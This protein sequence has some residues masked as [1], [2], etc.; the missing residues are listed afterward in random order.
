MQDIASFG[1]LLS[2]F[3]PFF[4]AP[5]DGPAAGPAPATAELPD[6]AGIPASPATIA[7]DTAGE[8]FDTAP[9]PPGKLAGVYEAPLAA[10]A[11]RQSMAF[12]FQLE[13]SVRQ[14]RSV[15]TSRDTGY[16]GSSFVEAAREQTS[17]SYQS[18][19]ALYRNGAGGT[20]REVRSFQAQMFR[21][22]TRQLSATLDPEPGGRLDRTAGRVS[23]TFEL[24]IKFEASFLSQFVRQAEDIS[25][26][27]AGVFQQYLNGTDGFAGGPADPMQ[28]FFDQVDTILADTEGFVK[29]TLSAFLADVAASFGMSEQ[30]AN[31]LENFVVEE[32]SSFFQD[33]DRFLE[34]ARSAFAMPAPAPQ[35]P[36]PQLAEQ[37]S[38]PAEPGAASLP[39]DVES[40][41]EVA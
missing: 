14:E 16:G 3:N 7:P 5:T 33:V 38:E 13:L 9:K 4:R 11:Q 2:Q 24:N 40:D 32:V 30:E 35:T 8:S 18:L 10:V 28:A 41:P 37:V 25:A 12:D 22:R 23:R 20:F 31:A 39:V 34:D 21:S 29:E 15:T 36:E 27:G 17:L 6:K 1:D 19:Q 26:M